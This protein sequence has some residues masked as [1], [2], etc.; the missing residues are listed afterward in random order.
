MGTTITPLEWRE[1][2]IDGLLVVTM[3]HAADERGV[4][5][6]FYRESAWVEAGLPSLGPWLQVNLTETKQ[7]AVR[8]LHGEAMTKLIGLAS[9]TAFGAYLDARAASPTYGRVVTLDL[10]VGMQVLVPQGV[11]NGFQSLTAPVTQYLYC[12]DVEWVP[13]MAGTAV[14]PLDEGLAI[15]WPLPIDRDDP[16]QVSV[17]DATAPPFSPT[18]LTDQPR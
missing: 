6:E 18:T 2:D 15:D 12:F 8:G 3:K 9:G 14:T 11:C 5:R 1:T 17:K 16:A 13:G 7:G 4:V 10:A